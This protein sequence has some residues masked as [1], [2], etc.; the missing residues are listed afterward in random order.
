MED[1][2]QIQT[3]FEMPHPEMAG[4]S[5]LYQREPVEK[6]GDKKLNIYT[7]SSLIL[8]KLSLGSGSHAKSLPGTISKPKS[9]KSLNVQHITATGTPYDLVNVPTKKGGVG[10]Q[11]DGHHFEYHFTRSGHKIYRCAWHLKERCPSQLLVFNRKTYVISDDHSHTEVA[12]MSE[13]IL[14]KTVAC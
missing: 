11:H 13:D 6:A 7:T 1:Y 8:N 5:V 9:H 3:T 10:V 2:S 12:R 14:A 4:V